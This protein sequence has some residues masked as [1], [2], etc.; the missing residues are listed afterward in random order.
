LVELTRDRL[1]RD[2]HHTISATPRSTEARSK[3]KS[4]ATGKS[5]TTDLR[6]QENASP[7]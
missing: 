5:L 1:I 3:S 2:G 6:E 4:I 7:E